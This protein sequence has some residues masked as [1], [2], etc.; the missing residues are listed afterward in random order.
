L[1]LAFLSKGPFHVDCLNLAINAEKTL[2]TLQM[3]Y[4]FGPGYPLTVLLGA[5][6]V[7]L[8]KIFAIADFVIAVNFVSV[9]FG[10]LCILAHYSLVR[11]LLDESCA[12]FSSLMLSI[13]PIF[14]ILSVYGNSH[15]PSLFFLLAG[16]SSLLSFQT[17]G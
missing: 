10:A 5:I 9:F 12:F 2:N 7:G 11:K 14:L 15:T 16:I 13:F 6:F 17:N 3:H 4:L 8:A 1:R